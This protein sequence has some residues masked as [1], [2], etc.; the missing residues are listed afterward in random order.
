MT[1]VILNQRGIR[2]GVGE[3]WGGTEAIYVLTLDA[4]ILPRVPIFQSAVAVPPAVTLSSPCSSLRRRN[5]LAVLAHEGTFPIMFGAIPLPVG[6]GH[7]TGY[8]ARPDESG[9]FP[10]VVVLPDLGGLDSFE[11]DL[12]RRLARAGVV[13]IAV[14]LYRSDDDPLIAYNSLT[15]TR[16]LTDLDEVHDFIVSD[17]ITWNA[18]NRVGLLGI[19]VGGRFALLKAA[20]T[21]WVGSAAV[22]YTP[23]TGDEDRERQVAEILSNLPV[24]ILGLYG[25]SDELIDSASVDEAQ[26]RNEHGQWLL[27][28][29]AGHGFIDPTSPTY[30]EGPAEDAVA[31]LIAFFKTTLPP[32]EI[33]ELG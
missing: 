25:A 7:R 26:R 1:T 21:S 31:R 20:T 9:R 18:G 22:A 5:L 2:R 10:V 16:A 12:C 23:L 15:D 28:E 33:E 19:D 27:Y 13:A 6:A 24:P 30:D 29:D 8:L 14:D 17:D 32:A 3:V 4:P 11:K